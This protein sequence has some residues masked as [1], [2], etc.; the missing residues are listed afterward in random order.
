MVDNELAS[1][2]H[3]VFGTSGS[4]TGYCQ[5][6][7]KCHPACNEEK[8]QDGKCPDSCDGISEEF[9]SIAN[10]WK[11]RQ[12]AE[13]CWEKI[14]APLKEFIDKRRFGIIQYYQ[15][16]IKKELELLNTEKNTLDKL[17]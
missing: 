10:D 5:I 15:E 13:C 11:G 14:F 9:I 7:K 6:C 16:T 4:C 2:I 17:T 1:F 3:Y 12:V 8:Y